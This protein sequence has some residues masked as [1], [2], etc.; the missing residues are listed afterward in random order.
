MWA[1]DKAGKD[2]L[3]LVRRGIKRQFVLNIAM[4]SL[5]VISPKINTGG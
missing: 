1:K 3:N 5:I 4:N 2:Q